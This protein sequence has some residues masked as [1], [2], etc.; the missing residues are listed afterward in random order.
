MFIIATIISHKKAREALAASEVKIAG[1]DVLATWKVLICLGIA[2]G[3]YAFYAVVA[4]IIVAKT[5]APL[6]W[7]IWTP[8][9]VITALPF[10]NYAA[11]KFGEAGMDVLKSLRP[12]I[13]ALLPGQ[14]KS[15]DKLKAQRE[16]LANEVAAMINDYGPKI[17]EEFD[18]FRI[19]VPSAS[20][21]PSTGT[22]GLWRRKSGTGAVDAQGL[23]LT[24]PMTWID[25]RLFGWSKSA[26]RG[27][28]AWSGSA[29]DE[30]SRLPTP[31][32]TDDE[33][34]GD[35]DNVV[36]VIH[37]DQSPDGQK[38]KSRQSSYADLQRLRVSSSDRLNLNS[39]IASTTAI[40]NDTLQFRRK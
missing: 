1:R 24:H 4:T 5:N 11:L 21:P 3:L 27:T 12:L 36:G 31:E 25:E 7:R 35:Y 17:Y 26:R 23:G 30:G 13:V 6:K 16:Y 29:T 19:L 22:P 28:N 14:Q 40:E 39:P 38:V 20:V 8:F 32:D 9:L 18:K 2:P 37:D 15:L 10:M 34:M 33:D